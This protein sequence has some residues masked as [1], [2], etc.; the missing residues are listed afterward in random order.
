MAN[1]NIPATK[2]RT[3]DAF[4]GRMVGGGA[5]PNLFECEMYFPDDAVPTTCLLYTSP[6]QRDS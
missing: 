3:L 1:L 6:S 4:K 5:R 2:D